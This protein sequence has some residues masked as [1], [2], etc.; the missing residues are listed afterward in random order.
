MDLIFTNPEQTTIKATL[1]EGEV[2]GNMQGPLECF[3]PC[4][5]A[6]K[7]YSE[8]LEQS[9]AVADYVPPTAA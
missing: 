1:V 8:I 6:N 7:E 9:L 2:L 3:I 5:P 4:D